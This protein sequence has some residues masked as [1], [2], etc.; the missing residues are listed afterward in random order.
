M[1]NMSD[2]FEKFQVRQGDLRLVGADRNIPPS[3]CLNSPRFTINQACRVLRCKDNRSRR[4][5]TWLVGKVDTKLVYFN[6][7]RVS[8]W[9]VYSTQLII[10]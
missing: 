9:A 1:N 7:S 4:Y 3:S 8:K 6:W 5:S 2:R 10:D